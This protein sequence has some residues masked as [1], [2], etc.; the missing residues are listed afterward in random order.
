M[1]MRTVKIGYIVNYFNTNTG[2]RA[3]EKQTRY[4]LLEVGLGNFAE[5][6]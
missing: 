3:Y 5:E 4:K 1:Y 6:R 2:G